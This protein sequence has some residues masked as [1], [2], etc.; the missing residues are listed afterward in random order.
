M[1]G[2][3]PEQNVTEWY[4]VGPNRKPFGPFSLPKLREYVG[5]GRI[6]RTTYVF[7]RGTSGWV[8]AE[9]VDGLFETKPSE[10]RSKDVSA[11]PVAAPVA[12]S[13]PIALTCP[14]CHVG[15]LRKA[16]S[17][18]MSTP[19]VVT[20]YALLVLSLVI[21]LPTSLMLIDG[22]LRATA[23]NPDH[24]AVQRATGADLQPAI[25][26]EVRVV[27]A[28]KGLMLALAM[29]VVGVL[30]VMSKTTLRCNRCGT[31]IAAS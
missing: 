14:T 8:K 23:V 18:R 3:G 28:W 6:T 17:Y 7:R 5:S 22:F 11:A 27:P 16:R 30:L 26:W 20:G 15:I 4:V 29:L 13:G 10:E 19:A 1:A 12:P 21:A 31:S 24:W 9:S 2:S 25:I